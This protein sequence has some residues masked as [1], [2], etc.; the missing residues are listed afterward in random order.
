MSRLSRDLLD[1]D[2]LQR[3]LGACGEGDT[4]T[5]NRALF[6]LMAATGLRVSEALAIEF[7]DLDLRRRRL[8]VRRG[9][10][11]KERRVWIDPEADVP[12]RA[13]FDARR[14]LGLNGGPVFCSLQGT[15]M[16]ASYVRRLLPRLAVRAGIR[17]RVHAHGLRHT[18]ACNAHRAKISLRSLQLQLGHD[19]IA[20]TSRYLERIGVEEVFAEFERAFA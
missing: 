6:A 11:G 9:K 16:D 2:E 4:A 17:K 3:L 5:R 12:V 18:F 10:G 13:W 20:T 8:H 19:S 7:R 1:P 15:R 14:T